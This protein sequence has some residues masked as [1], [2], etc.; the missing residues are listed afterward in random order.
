MQR[1]YI[2]ELKVWY[3]ENYFILV[4][5]KKLSL[6]KHKGSYINPKMLRENEPSPITLLI[7]IKIK[8]ICM[9]MTMML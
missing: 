1:Y 2:V 4:S 9:M 5:T 6:S 7:L 3:F 8:T